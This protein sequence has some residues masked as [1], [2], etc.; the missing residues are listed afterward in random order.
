MK[1]KNINQTL[2]AMDSEARSFVNKS[3]NME[4]VKLEKPKEAK[5]T[6]AQNNA[7]HL[8]LSQLATI[9]NDAGIDMVLLLETLNGKA[10][11]PCTCESLK[12]RFYKPILEHLTNKKSTAK[13]DTKEIDLVHQTACRIMAESF[14]IPAP[15]SPD[16]HFP[17][18]K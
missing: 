2:I 16:R 5:R 3:K 12:E 4:I 6:D 7:L 15:P 11:I 17:Y 9:C 14:G 1:F 13:M 8:W 10:E 18:E